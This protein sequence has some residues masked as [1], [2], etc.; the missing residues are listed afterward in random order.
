MS[1]SDNQCD[2]AALLSGH[3]CATLST[4]ASI[5][6]SRSPPTADVRIDLEGGRGASR[7]HQNI[8]DG[9]RKT[10]RERGRERRREGGRERGPKTVKHVFFGSRMSNGN[11]LSGRNLIPQKSQGHKIFQL[12]PDIVLY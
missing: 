1:H 10:G 8:C 4:S 11:I 5:L 7:R 3:S 2:S 6:E 12:I 9:S